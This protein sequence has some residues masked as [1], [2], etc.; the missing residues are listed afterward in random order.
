MES[1]LLL[2]VTELKQESNIAISD[3]YVNKNTAG[4]QALAGIILI[5]SIEDQNQIQNEYLSVEP[6]LLVENSEI[7]QN[8]LAPI[9]ETCSIQI[10]GLNP[11]QILIKNSTIINRS[12]PN[13]NKQYELKIALPKD[14]EPKDLI[15]QFQQVDFGIILNPVTV[16]TLPDDQFQNLTILT[17]QY[18]N[19]Q[20]S[21]NGQESCTSYIANFHNDVRTLSC[22]MIIIRAQ[23]TLGQLKG[24]PRQI[25]ISGLFTENDLRTDG[26]T[27][28]FKGTNFQTQ[29]NMISFQ[30]YLPI[31]TDPI[32][33]SLFRVY[34]DGAV[35]LSNLF[36]QRSNQ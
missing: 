31:S 21:S 5:H 17:E 28:S 7:T 2:S 3:V 8:T 19:I 32:D 26:L 30:P 22:A 9:S 16:K 1:P 29:A 10:E 34:D 35:T 18:T 6:I 12:Q 25:S 23:E 33:S 27:V 13:N 4:T 20:V 24:V 36:I 14:C 11:Q 15:S